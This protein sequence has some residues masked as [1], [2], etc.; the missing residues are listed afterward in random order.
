MTFFD[1]GNCPDLDMVT[2][3]LTHQT[4]TG[5]W[6]GEV[7]DPYGTTMQ[8]TVYCEGNALWK[9]FFR[10]DSGAQSVTIDAVDAECAPFTITY[11][12]NLGA[13]YC[14]GGNPSSVTIVVTY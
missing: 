13:G 1:S 3:A 11:N 7:V 10:W 8:V 2:G 5:F 14:D 4:G 9:M 6:N 12:P